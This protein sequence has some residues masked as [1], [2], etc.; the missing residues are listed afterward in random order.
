[1]D[2]PPVATHTRRVA[3][4][5]AELPAR[6]ARCTM[7]GHRRTLPYGELVEAIAARPTTARVRT[8][9]P[10]DKPTD[11]IARLPRLSRAR[12]TQLKALGIDAISSIRL[13]S[14]S[15]RNRS[16]S[17][18]PGQRTA[19]CREGYPTE[20]PAVRTSRLLSRFEAMMP[21]IP[22]YEGLVPIRRSRFMELH[23]RDCDDAASPEVSC[24]GAKTRAGNSPKF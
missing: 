3:P 22:L 21:P 17:A 10:Q 9:A 12:A 2:G 20:P 8:D 19:V 13:I 4:R 6:L 5:L 11:S 18:R 16:S 14:L 1:M 24:D 7:S 15:R 23:T